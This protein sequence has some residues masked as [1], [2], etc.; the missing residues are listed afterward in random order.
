MTRKDWGED[1]LICLVKFLIK[2]TDPK[3]TGFNFFD[4]EWGEEHSFRTR[5]EL[6][7]VEAKHMS[8]MKK[9]GCF[10]IK[11]RKYTGGSIGSR[12]HD[13]KP[14]L[15][16]VYQKLKLAGSLQDQQDG[17]AG[18]APP[19]SEDG[20]K[21]APVQDSSIAA[22]S[23][24]ASYQQSSEGLEEKEAE[25]FE[26]FMENINPPDDLDRQWIEDLNNINYDRDHSSEHVSGLEFSLEQDSE[27]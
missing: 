15:V 14:Q 5:R 11:N 4:E 18:R 21:N 3:R 19:E 17:A 12:I 10:K 20:S 13:K 1:E 27:E 24:L 26:D 9:K 6:F 7:K 16:D 25:G 23:S 2:H 22:E 8:S